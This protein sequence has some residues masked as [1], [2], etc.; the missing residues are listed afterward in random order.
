M[1]KSVNQ[2]RPASIERPSMLL[3]KTSPEALRLANRLF[4]KEKIEINAEGAQFVFTLH[5]YLTLKQHQAFLTQ[6][7][8]N[9]QTMACA[10][11]EL[12]PFSEQIQTEV[13]EMNRLD[14]NAPEFE[15]A[16]QEIE[17]TNLALHVATAYIYRFRG[18]GT[19][20][21][22]FNLLMAAHL[23]APLMRAIDDISAFSSLTIEGFYEKCGFRFGNSLNRLTAAS[24]KLILEGTHFSD[25]K[26]FYLNSVFDGTIDFVIPEI[27]IK[28]RVQ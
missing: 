20:L 22:A 13:A 11:F 6:V 14:S 8:H 4:D 28:S 17:Y 3:K 21:L 2:L 27:G 25:E 19:T 10:Q 18:I 15:E 5:S 26:I 1:A 7:S 16:F 24:R 9:G 23:G 12:A